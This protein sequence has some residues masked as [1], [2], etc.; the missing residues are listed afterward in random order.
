MM[1]SVLELLFRTSRIANETALGRVR[2]QSGFDIR[3]AH[4]LLF[5]HITPEGTRITEIAAKL[6]VSKQA[7]AKLVEELVGFGWLERLP[8]PTDGRAKL[9][10]FA[11]GALEHGLSHLKAY[12]DEIK[13]ELG[14]EDFKHFRSL[15]AKVSSVVEEL[16]RQCIED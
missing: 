5:P 14:E 9:V 3:P 16:E 6:G 8:D 13:T 10:R 15:L 11:P 7:V 2:R 12:E 4:S 1:N